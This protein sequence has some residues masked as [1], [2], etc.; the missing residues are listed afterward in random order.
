MSAT[1]CGAIGIWGRCVRVCE[2]FYSL[3]GEGRHAGMAAYFVRLAGCDVGCQWCDSKESWHGGQV[4]NSLDIAERAVAFGAPTVVVTGGEPLMQPM[5]ELTDALH[6][7]GL[8][9]HLE[10]S[11]TQPM[12]GLFDWICLSPKRHRPPLHEFFCHTDE[13]KVV[14]AS[15][16]DFAW[17][18]QCA[19]QALAGAETEH[20]GG[21]R[22]RERTMHAP[23]LYLQAEWGA[24][25][26][27][28]EE[29]VEYIKENPRWRLSL[30]T[31]KFLSIR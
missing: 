22:R 21:G 25:A 16:E 5:G 10:T 4:C 17:A 30:Q 27:I 7:R 14:I 28:M 6:D 3:Q 2:E 19:A 24:S 1:C 11:G 31:H 26:A 15:F 8:T 9:V 29:I 12:S 18:E 20:T 23:L 13:L